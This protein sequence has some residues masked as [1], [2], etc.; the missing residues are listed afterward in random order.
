MI[1]RKL[2]QPGPDVVVL[3]FIIALVSWLAAFIWPQPP[4]VAGYHENP[5]PLF[6]FLTMIAGFSSLSGVIAAF[7]MMLLVSVLMV[8]FNTDVFFIG[9]RQF[10]PALIYILIIG[11]VPEQ[12][13]LNPVLPAAIFLIPAVQRIMM[14]YKLQWTPF[15][16]FDAG[17]LIGT[18][19]LFY[20]GLIWFGLLLFTGIVILRTWGIREFIVSLAGLATP[21][22]IFTGFYYVAGN[23]MEQLMVS[24]KHNL[25]LRSSTLGPDIF[26]KAGLAVASFITLICLVHLLLALNSK[27][28]KS[29]KTFVLLIWIF[30]I[31]AGMVILFQA[32]SYEIIWLAAIPMSYFVSHYFVFARERRIP[33]I[34]LI[35]LLSMV[36]IIQVLRFFP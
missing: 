25:F 5:L 14:A 34:M 22:F 28:V 27:K 12:H 35:T 20:A 21:L 26:S 33:V 31:S 10:F 16:F 7:L 30:L 1:I 4:S 29:R 6:R 13:I 18:G 2:R 11:L 36:I 17:L 23:D 8:N 19:S 24:V 15:P 9:E 32:V 3:I